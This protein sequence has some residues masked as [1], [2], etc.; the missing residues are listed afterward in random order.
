MCCSTPRPPQSGQAPNGLLNENSRGSTS[1]MVKPDTGQA[2]FSEKIMR[3]AFSLRPALALARVDGAVGELDH[4]HALGELEALLQR[5]R[6]PRGDVGAHHQAVDHHV[7]VVG[8]LLVERLDLADLVER[9][10]DLDALVALLEVLGE[11]LAVLALAAAHDRR[12]HI[13]AGALGQR[14]HAVDHLRHGLA[15]DRQAGGGRVGHADA[16]PQQPH[17]VVDLGDG[18]D[19]RARVLRGGLLLDGDGGR[20]A[21]D[22]VDVR[23]LH[24]LQE[25]PGIGRQRL[26]VA[27]L[28]LGVD[29][30]EGER[31][32]AGAGQAG[33]HHELVA[34]ELDVDVLEVVLARA[35]D[36][37]HAAVH[38][39]FRG[40]NAGA[41]APAFFKQIVHGNLMDGGA[42]PSRPE[43]SENRAVSPVPADRSVHV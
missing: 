43:R 33:E 39:V 15:L 18:A 10:V 36:R 35:A 40:G 2:N 6:E 11:L 29:G 42:R 26:D 22:L 28:A 14:Q 38:R 19:R 5:I 12:Q 4:R 23:L 31:G 8:E 25:L 13:D 3:S 9:A 41:G 24:H 30:V 20:Q 32:F 1:E 16:R 21:V 34:R 17:V 37:D 7:D 27:A